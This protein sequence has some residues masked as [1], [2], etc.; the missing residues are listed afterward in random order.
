MTTGKVS[1]QPVAGKG[2]GLPGGCGSPIERRDRDSWSG[3][4]GEPHLR[5]RQRSRSVG[6][7]EDAH[8]CPLDAD[9]CFTAPA[10][11]SPAGDE[12]HCLASARRLE[13]VLLH[14]MDDLLAE[15]GSLHVRGAEVDPARDAGVDDLIERV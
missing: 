11:G 5:W 8:A 3:R 9:G 6:I 10:V 15:H 4:V 12:P 1:P 7:S 14:V 2:M 13:V